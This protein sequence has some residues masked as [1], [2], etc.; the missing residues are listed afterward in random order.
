MLKKAT[1]A[2]AVVLAAGWLVSGS[3]QAQDESQPR[4]DQ[5]TE[6]NP[7]QT[8]PT[9]AVAKCRS[10]RNRNRAISQRRR[11]RRPRLFRRR[12]PAIAMSSPRPQPARRRVP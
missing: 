7:S 5:R 4:K 8:G 10:K 2:L 6:T 1:A 12:R 11:R 3:A 9:R